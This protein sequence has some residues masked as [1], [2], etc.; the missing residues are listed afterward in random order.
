MTEPMKFDHTYELLCHHMHQLVYDTKQTWLVAADT[1][2]L[3]IMTIV[4]VSGAD[5]KCPL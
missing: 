5:Q 1:D 4:Q 2:L 3:V